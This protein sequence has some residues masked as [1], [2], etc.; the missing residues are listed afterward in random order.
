MSLM[1]LVVAQNNLASAAPNMMVLKQDSGANLSEMN[2]SLYSVSTDWGLDAFGVGEAVKFTTPEPDWRLMQVRILGW[3]RFNET[4]RTIPPANN[5]LIEIRDENLNLLYRMA[6]TQNAYFTYP[7]PVI[8]S[9]DIPALPLSGDFYVVFYD[10]GA[11]VVGME[12]DNGTG[13][14]YLYDS[15]RSNLIPATFKDENNVS[16]QVNWVIRAVGE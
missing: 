9:I 11:M 14:S 8:R 13:N 7:A 10:R 2:L 3:N 6:D 4:T 16:T 1:G 12:S 15:L 5:F